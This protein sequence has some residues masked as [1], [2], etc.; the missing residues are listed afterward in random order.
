M[1]F[2]CAWKRRFALLAGIPPT[3]GFHAKLV[4]LEAT[5]KA[6]LR[7]LMVLPVITS[8]FGAF[9]YLRIAKPGKLMTV[10]FPTIS[11]SLPL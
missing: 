5:M 7:W 1:A 10:C 9:Y 4:V 3:I 11:R 6:G 8:L 2:L